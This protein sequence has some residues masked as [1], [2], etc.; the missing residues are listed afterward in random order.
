MFVSWRNVHEGSWFIQAF[1]DNMFERAYKDHFMDILTEVNRRVA[2]NFQSRCRDKQIP[3]P[4]STLTRK[5]Q[6]T[7]SGDK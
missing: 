2:F 4:V 3:A 7:P 1:V 5:L 6:F